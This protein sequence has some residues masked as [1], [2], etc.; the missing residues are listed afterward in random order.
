MIWQLNKVFKDLV[1][2]YLSTLPS[3]VPAEFLGNFPSA[4]QKGCSSSAFRPGLFFV[5]IIVITNSASSYRL[6]QIYFLFFT[7]VSLC[8]CRNFSI[9][10]SLSN[11]LS[12]TYS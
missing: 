5:E 4:C 11:L 3:V 7:F 10:S 8:I 12:Y 1:S 2:F 9:S 6:L